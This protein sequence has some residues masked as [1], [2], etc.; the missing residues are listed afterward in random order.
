MKL[1]MVGAGRM[2]GSMAVRLLRAGYDVVVY[3][4]N[5]KAIARVVEAGAAAALSLE[6]LVGKLNPPRTVWLMLSPG[7]VTEEAFRTA[8]RILQPGDL[9][10]DGGNSYWQDSVRRGADLAENGIAF[11]DVGTSG[12]IWGQEEGYCLMVGGDNASINHA[13]GIFTAL[14]FRGSFAH[15]GPVGAGH[16][17]KMVHNGIEYGMLAAYGEGFEILHESPFDLDLLQVANVWR[18]GSVL[19]SWLLELL[20]RSLERDPDLGSITGYVE[21]SGMGRWTVQA[22]IDEQVPA[23]VIT[24]ALFSRFAS[25]QD[26]SFAGKVIASLRQEF[27][28][29]AVRPTEPRT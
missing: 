11:V 5:D 2:G 20:I 1:G 21:D 25:R 29:H 14:G 26:E 22:A 18:G 23:Y 16:F 9:L 19:R 17:V 13:R 12:G 8:R 3:D 27:G 28:G 24:A 6:D 7:E 15:I 4:L 10:I